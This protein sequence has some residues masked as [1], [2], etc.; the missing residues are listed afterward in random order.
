M[1]N[2]FLAFL[3]YAIYTTSNVHVFVVTTVILA[4]LLSIHTLADEDRKR[5]ENA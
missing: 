5:R 1:N 4:G 3:P 2:L